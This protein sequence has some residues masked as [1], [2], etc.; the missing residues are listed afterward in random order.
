[1]DRT[2]KNW[3]TEEGISSLFIGRKLLVVR[4]DNMTLA[5]GES[6][7][8]LEVTCYTFK[9]DKLSTFSLRPQKYFAPPTAFIAAFLRTVLYISLSF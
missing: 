5:V 2:V 3:Y 7:L 9:V 1:M 6:D 8:L 4:R